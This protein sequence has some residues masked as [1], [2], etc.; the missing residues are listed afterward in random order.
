MINFVSFTLK[1]GGVTGTTVKYDAT[2]G[3]DTFNKNGLTVNV[4]TLLHCITAASSY[5]QKSIE[6]RLTVVS[7]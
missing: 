6:V 5:S 2:K 4:N 3:T 7:H 1:T